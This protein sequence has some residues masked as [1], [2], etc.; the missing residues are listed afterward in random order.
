MT[1]PSNLEDPADDRKTDWSTEDLFSEKPDTVRLEKGIP[2]F[3]E[4]DRIENFYVLKNGLLG[5]YRFIQ[6]TKRILLHKILPGATTGVTQLLLEH[7]FPA[8]L[9]PIKESIAYK[10]TKKQLIDLKETNPDLV[11]Q[12]LLQ[13][14]EAHCEVYEKIEQVLGGNVDERIARELLDLAEQ[15]GRAT[16]EGDEIIVKLTRKD[17]SQMVACSH[18]TASRVMSEWE[19]EGTIQ[20]D[21]KKIT[22]KNPH[23]LRSYF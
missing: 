10:G 17:V 2:I 7:P 6:P 19:K 15:I 14:S 5:L 20:T 18:E 13:E 9:V 23:K 1:N 4:R 3:S 21:H 16:E 8:H 11:N 22:I 12:L